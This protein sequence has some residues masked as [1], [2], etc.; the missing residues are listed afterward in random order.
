MG[1]QFLNRILRTYAPDG[2]KEISLQNLRNKKIAIDTS[3]YMYR[4]QSENSLIE[5]M[6]LMT[7]DRSGLKCIAWK[8]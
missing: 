6:Y 3:I 8:Y 4:F 7:A 2:I 5:N 1:I